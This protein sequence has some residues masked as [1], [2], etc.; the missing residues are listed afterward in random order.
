MRVRA[1][2]Y[3]SDKVYVGYTPNFDAQLE[4]GENQN[5]VRVEY[6]ISSRWTFESHYGD[7]RAGGAALIWSKD[8]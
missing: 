4:E 7:G 5:E 2:K 6:Q 3:I 1:G 8:Y